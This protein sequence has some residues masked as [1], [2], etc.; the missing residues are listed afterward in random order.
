[1]YNKKAPK[2]AGGAKEE[3]CANSLSCKVGKQMKKHAT[4]ATS[5]MYNKKAPLNVKKID[6][7]AK[8][9]GQS[10]KK[11]KETY[12]KLLAGKFKDEAKGKNATLAKK[13]LAKNVK[14][15]LAK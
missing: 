15:V 9:M 4:A 5:G 13:T 6:K 11:M 1:M 8:K 3:D 7:E 2:T 14:K 10:K 12:Q